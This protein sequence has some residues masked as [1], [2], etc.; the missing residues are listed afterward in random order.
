M[1]RYLL[2]LSVLFSGIVSGQDQHTV[3]SL[4]QII[5]KKPQDTLTVKAFKALSWEY[6]GVDNELYFK[7]SKQVLELA[8]KFDHQPFIADSFLDF[9]I[10]HEYRGNGDSALFYYK[11]SEAI[12]KALND[13]DGLTVV[14]INAGSTYR[15]LGNFSKAIEYNLM[16]LRLAEKA[17]KKDRMADCKNSIGNIYRQKRNFDNA[18][19]YSMESLELYRQ[20]S[21]LEGISR[22]S[23]NIGII[24]SELK[25][26]KKAL[27]YYFKSLEIRLKLNSLSSISNCYSSI[28]CEYYEMDRLKEAIEYHNKA[29]ELNEKLNNKKGIA[30]DNTNIAAVC[31][32]EKKYSSAI[33]RLK[34]AETLAVQTKFRDLLK[35][36][37]LAS[38]QN[39]DS[40]ADYKQAYLYH[41]KFEALKDSIFNDNENSIIAEM[42]TKY[43]TDKKDS[44]IM[45]LNKEKELQEADIKRKSIIIWSILIGLVLVIF[46]AIYVFKSYRE[47]Q[48]ANE[49]ITKQKEEVEMQKTI[50]EEKQKEILDS[51]HY[52]GRIQKA[53]LPSDKYIE[54]N[55]KRLSK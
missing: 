45:L 38:S 13:E 46:L 39:Y 25:D 42:Q 33:E 1:K 11:K 37:Y 41:K 51:I 21:N 54:K 28:A 6:E 43:E 3:D 34:V 22:V 44:E 9:G 16:A 4:L 18:L 29:L 20:T 14:Y 15:S 8:K 23:N 24:Y 19:K 50:I 7:Y 5:N 32:K 47:K 2:F 27:E 12:Y 53:L 48:R 36:V 26:S 35:E 10:A 31:T 17:N 30:I 55:I 40:L 49:I 52:A